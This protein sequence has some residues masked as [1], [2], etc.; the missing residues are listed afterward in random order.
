MNITQHF[1][2][3]DYN[4][5]SPSAK[6]LVL[7]KGF[8]NIPF[9]KQTAEL[10]SAQD[11]CHVSPGNN[12]VSF[13]KRVVHFEIRHWS[14][15]QLLSSLPGTN[16]LELSAGYSFR[17]LEI[18]RRKNVC[19]VDTD[20]PEVISLKKDLLS[21][22]QLDTTSNPG[23]LETISLN[24]LDAEQFNKVVD[25]FPAGPIII[26]NEGLL[27]YLNKNEKK[28]LCGII[29]QVLK[30]RGGYWIT[31]DVYVRSTLERFSGQQDSLKDLV[32]AER[33]EDNMFE[34][35]DAAEEFFKST[36]FS[37]V[38]EAE[39]NLE[40]ISSLPY[41]I[42]NATEAQLTEMKTSTK[43]IQTT[44]CLKVDGA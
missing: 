11:S 37:I 33:I 20:L 44:W 5:I 16:I 1:E 7:L 30:K 17:G 26:I 18:T 28:I 21:K 32:E 40:K 36:G 34:G 43:K 29:H 35:L 22:L 4:A 24:A 13:W 41:L 19:Y 2:K 39:V 10:F 6:S 12:D 8:T 25:S 38:E 3:R 31:A 42:S 27:M 15:D 23:T 9:A 14:I